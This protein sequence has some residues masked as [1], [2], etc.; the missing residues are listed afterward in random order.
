LIRHKTDH[1]E[2]FEIDPSGKL[3]FKEEDAEVKSVKTSSASIKAVSG[4]KRQRTFSG[5]DE[6]QCDSDTEKTEAKRPSK[7][8]TTDI[9]VLEDKGNITDT[10]TSQLSLTSVR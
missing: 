4:R 10:L 7:C 9:M 6:E 8:C 3:V 5:V 1:A 2:E